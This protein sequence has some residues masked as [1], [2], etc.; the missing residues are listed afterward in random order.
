MLKFNLLYF[1]DIKYYLRYVILCKRNSYLSF[2]F[3]ILFY[4]NKS[5]FILTIF[6]NMIQCKSLKGVN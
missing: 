2:L 5:T 3:K 4:L 6:F 1:H